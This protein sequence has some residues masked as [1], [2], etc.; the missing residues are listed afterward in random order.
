MPIVHGRRL[1]L[2][3]LR[4]TLR[5][6]LFNIFLSDLF[7][8]TDEIESACQTD[9]NNLYETENIIK[10]VILSLQESFK[11]LFKWFS[12]NEMRSN[13][14]KSHLILMDLPKCKWENL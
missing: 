10:H 4:G 1:Y 8:I 3:Y 11:N 12:D 14:G 9:D 13:S 2:E 6:I 7:L 5:P